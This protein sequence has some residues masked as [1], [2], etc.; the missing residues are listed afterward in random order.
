MKSTEWFGRRA[1]IPVKKML[2]A[3]EVLMLIK[4]NKALLNNTKTIKFT[5]INIPDSDDSVVIKKY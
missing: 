5:N 2:D 1:T 4:C 3:N